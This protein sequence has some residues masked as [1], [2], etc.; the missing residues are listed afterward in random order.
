MFD[1]RPSRRE[2]VRTAS[3]GVTAGLAGCLDAS[4]GTPEEVEVARQQWSVSIVRPGYRQ[5][6]TELPVYSVYRTAAAARAEIDAD[7]RIERYSDTDAGPE[8][9]TFVEETEFDRSTLVLVRAQRVSDVQLEI[10]SVERTQT[11][12]R[13]EIGVDKPANGG[14]VGVLYSL[15]LRITDRRRDSNRIDVRVDSDSARRV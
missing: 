11:G 7:G 6:D 3:L 15:L 9:A 8:V 12:L 2:F 1:E 4:G 5:S 14:D 10:R 13:V